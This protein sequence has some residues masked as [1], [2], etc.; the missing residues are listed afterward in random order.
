MPAQI[1]DGKA[2]ALILR[3]G[4]AQEVSALEKDTGI[5]PGLA[6]VLVDESDAEVE[7][8]AT[9]GPSAAPSPAPAAAAKAETAE[10][11]SPH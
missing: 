1:I 2:L 9:A 6:A 7:P 3:E 4:I 10:V 5:Q 11:E 8:T